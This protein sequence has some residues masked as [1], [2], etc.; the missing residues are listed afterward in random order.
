MGVSVDG[1]DVGVIGIGVGE[2]QEDNRKR[3]KVN[4]RK[5]RMIRII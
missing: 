2:V 3:Y 4:G 5:N 1:A